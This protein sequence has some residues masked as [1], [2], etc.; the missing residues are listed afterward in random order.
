MEMMEATEVME[1]AN[2][3]IGSGSASQNESYYRESLKE[4]STAENVQRYVS[5]SAGYGI[6]YLLQHVYG[7]L[8]EEQIDKLVTQMGGKEGL[9]ILEYGCG[10]GMNLIWIVK[11][12]SDRRINLDFACG[13][14]FSSKMVEAAKKEAAFGLPNTASSNVSFHTV[15]NGNLSRDLPKIL[16][17]PLADLQESFHLIV[18]V[19]TFR[20]CFRLG[21]QTESANEI[22]S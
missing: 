2:G 15:A 20:Y 12:L 13:T 22:F 14:D 10:G 9:R 1:S 16:G 17:R 3:T 6:A 19:N 4:Y 5:T 11:R 8:Y 18:G 7:A 21:T